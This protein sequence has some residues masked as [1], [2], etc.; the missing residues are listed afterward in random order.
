L[1]PTP[2]GGQQFREQDRPLATTRRAADGYRETAVAPGPADLR[3]D[4]PV[5]SW[6]VVEAVRLMRAL[7]A[8]APRCC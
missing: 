2:R 7:A 8:P 1:V 3:R 6:P 5:K 4:L